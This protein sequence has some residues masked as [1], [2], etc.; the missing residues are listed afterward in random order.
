MSRDYTV[1]TVQNAMQ[2]LRLFTIDKSEWTLTE[3]AREKEMSISTTKRLLQT[4]EK[5]GYIIK[6]HE[7]KKYK[8]SLSILSLSGIVTTTMDIHREARSVLL[9]LLES[10]G[11]AVHIG[12]LEGVQTVYLE[13]LESLYPVRLASF[14]GKSNPIY[15]SGCGKV[16]LAYKEEKEQ[17]KIIKTIERDGYHKYGSKTVKNTSELKEKL[18]S[19]QKQGYEICVDELS[20][21]I[22][23][24][25][26]PIYDY[27]ETVIAAISITGPNK[28]MDIPRMIEGVLKA[29]KEVSNRLGYVY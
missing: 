4:L 14:I 3:I 11:E 23:S 27:D 6:N 12:I 29:A 10:Y 7:S 16:L 2:I 19:I 13:K 1:Q 15:C 26:A 28:R 8:L 9:E 17:E 24:I 22:T 5:Y 21:G 20:T 25:A 18:R